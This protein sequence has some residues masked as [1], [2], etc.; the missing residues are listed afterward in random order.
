MRC[1][2]TLHYPLRQPWASL[3]ECLVADSPGRTRRL[4]R[5][6]KAAR[7]RLPIV[8]NGFSRTDRSPRSC[9]LGEPRAR[10]SS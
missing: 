5:I 2:T 1:V 10:R 9:W 7:G 3:S 8:L 4:M 6:L